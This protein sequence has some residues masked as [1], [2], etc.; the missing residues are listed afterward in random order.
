MPRTM[1]EL[2]QQLRRAERFAQTG[3][4]AFSAVKPFLDLGE[5]LLGGGFRGR[6]RREDK[7]D[8]PRVDPDEPVPAI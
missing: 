7:T 2:D 5:R 8:D 4:T 3:N 1:K 6:R